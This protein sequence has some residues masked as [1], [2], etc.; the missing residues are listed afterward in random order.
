MIDE[1][2]LI[3]DIWSLFNNEYNNAVKYDGDETKLA[4]RIL[5]H[6][7]KKIEAQPKIEQWIPCN[8][9]LP[10]IGKPVLVCDKQG[11]VCIRAITNKIKGKKYWSQDKIDV[12]AWQPLPEPYKE[13]D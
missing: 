5:S 7:Q 9:K 13:S 2:K 3:E 6:V 12:V 11:N 8:E 4:D 1:K 10:K